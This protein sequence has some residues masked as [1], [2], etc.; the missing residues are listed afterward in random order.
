MPTRGLG[1]EM[2][3][4]NIELEIYQKLW[5]LLMADPI[6][7]ALVPEGNRIRFDDLEGDEN[8]DKPNNADGDRASARLITKTGSFSFYTEGETFQTHAPGG[9]SDWMEKHEYIFRLT[10]TSQLLSLNESSGLA[11][12]SRQAIRAGGPKLGLS[13]VTSVKVRSEQLDRRQSQDIEDEDLAKREVVNHDI[14][15]GVEIAGE[16]LGG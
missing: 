5:Q 3:A 15:V 11:A 2:A 6:W 10:T 4:K 1:A 9:P 14:T 12:Q 16:S 7:A 13:Y 8:P